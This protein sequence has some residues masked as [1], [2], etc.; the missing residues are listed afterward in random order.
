MS[1]SLFSV[2]RYVIPSQHIRE[3]PHGVKDE[4]AVLQLAVTEYRPLD[5]LV[6]KPGSVTLIATHANG[7]PKESYEPLWDDLYRAFKGKIRAVWFA[8]CSHQGASGVLNEKLQGDDR[9]LPRFAY[10]LVL[11][12]PI[13]Q[14]NAPAGVNAALPSSFRPDFWSSRL[15][16]DASMRKNR[17]FQTWDPRALTEYLRYGLRETPTAIY[18]SAAVSGAVTLTTTKHQEAWSYVRSNFTP[19]LTGPGTHTERLISP[20]LDAENRTHIFHR[21]EMVLTFRSLP[22]IRPSVLWVFGAQSHINTPELREGKLAFTGTGVGGSGGVIAGRV[23]EVVVERSSHMLP[24]EK[25][26]ECSTIL[27]RWLEK[28]MDDF[29]AEERFHQQHN[30][31]KSERDMLLMS[32]LWLK[33]VRRK[34]NEKRTIKERL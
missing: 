23:E 19:M 22:F 15:Q 32:K 5:N 6:A 34:E 1:T 7:L 4:N 21:P 27:A 17:F 11:L 2:T 16:A 18:P 31:G 25:V 13:I 33:N 30:S 28:A 8:D 24:L 29:A 10:F 9:E 20:D 12:E 14:E 26:Q 3:Y